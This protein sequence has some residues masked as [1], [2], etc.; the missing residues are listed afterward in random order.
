MGRWIAKNVVAAK[1]AAKCEV[2]LAYAIGHPDPV[3]VHVDTFGT[4][5]VSSDKIARAINRV[6]SF[7]PADIIEQLDL[8][9]PIYGKTTNYGHFGK[10]DKDLTWER[11]D[12][13]AALRKAI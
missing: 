7:Q 2:Q 1:L 9:R 13:V 3:S 4:G 8:R 5:V 10:S 11:T 6:F 12:K